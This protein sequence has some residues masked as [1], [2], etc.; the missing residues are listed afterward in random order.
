MSDQNNLKLGDHNAI[1]DVCGFKSKASDLRKRWDSAM[2][3]KEDWES[4]HPMD[5][6]KGRPDDSSVPW[7][8]PDTEG[9]DVSPDRLDTTT[10]V[11]E[12]N[13]DGSL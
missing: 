9:E 13:N 1:C 6:F 11:P 7:S 10:D 2:V 3:C 12:G 4:R 8:R 5:F